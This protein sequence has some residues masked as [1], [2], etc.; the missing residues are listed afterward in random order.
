MASC[1]TYFV[2][3]G[4]LRYD[5]LA[6]FQEFKIGAITQEVTYCTE[7]AVIVTLLLPVL[8]TTASI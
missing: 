6:N 3:Y 8:I 1:D 5:N 2:S 4:W 7:P